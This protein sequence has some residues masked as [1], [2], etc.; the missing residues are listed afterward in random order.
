MRG[1]QRDKNREELLF[2]IMGSIELIFTVIE[3]IRNIGLVGDFIMRFTLFKLI[4]T[5]VFSELSEM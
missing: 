3:I 1:K 2:S 4:S 5:R